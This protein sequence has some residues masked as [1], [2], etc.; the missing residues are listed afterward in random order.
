[1][2]RVIAA[3]DPC[4]R[5]E[6]VHVDVVEP[7]VVQ[8]LSADDK[9]TIGCDR[10]EMCITRFRNEGRRSDKCIVSMDFYECASE[11]FCG[12]HRLSEPDFQL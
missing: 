9:E 11:K 10:R 7:D 6:I 5:R 2:P 3:L 12:T 8:V 1:M 4:L